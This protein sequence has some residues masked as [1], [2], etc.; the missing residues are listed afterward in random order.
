MKKLKQGK[1]TRRSYWIALFLIWAVMAALLVAGR[2]LGEPISSLR[3]AFLLVM[4]V[5]YVAVVVMRLR[6]TGQSMGFIA[7]CIFVPIFIFV[8]GSWPSLEM[9]MTVKKENG[10]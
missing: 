10:E 5:C 3:L 1:L 8:I 7:I 2:T 9:Q 6:D 4:F